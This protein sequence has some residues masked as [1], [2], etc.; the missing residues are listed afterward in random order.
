MW[1]RHVP[2][3]TPAMWK[4]RGPAAA[5]D[6]AADSVKRRLIYIA[7]AVIVI[8]LGLLVRWPGLGLPREVAKY[9]GSILWAAMVYFLLRALVLRWPIIVA[10]AV[11]ALLVALG[12]GHAADLDPLV[13]RHAR[14]DSG[15]SHLRP[16]LCR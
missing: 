8:A 7:V 4:W 13:R 9:A 1:G 11:A 15:T 2:L 12:G 16:H 6:H 5:P 3:Q 10:V 14:D